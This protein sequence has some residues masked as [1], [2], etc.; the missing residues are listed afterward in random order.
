[1][2]ADVPLGAF[3]SGGID[4]TVVALM[5]QLSGTPVRTFSIGSHSDA[6]NEA[7]H[8]KAVARHLGTEHTELYVTEKD[9]LALIP[10]LPLIYCEPFAD[11]QIPTYLVASL[12]R[13][14]VTV[15]LS[16]DG[17]DE[18]FSGYTRYALAT[19][20]WPWAGRI[21]SPGRALSAKAIHSVGPASWDRILAPILGVSRRGREHKRIG[22]KLHKASAVL[23]A[24]SSK[25]LYCKLVSHW[26]NPEALVQGAHEPDALAWEDTG[27]LMRI[28][29]AQ[30]PS[31]LSTRR[32]PGES[33]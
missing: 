31:R 33:R 22:D 13:R 9:A 25:D 2:L 18:L 1:M 3:L 7:Q 20:V 12:A 24:A 28:H 21:S 16:G 29:D 4:S 17:G 15:A 8:A 32:Y 19:R 30:R 26:Q 23:T 10:K 6:Y 27:S 5:Q 11:L 14:S